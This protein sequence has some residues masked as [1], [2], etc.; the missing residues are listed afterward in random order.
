MFT[1]D[2]EVEESY[3]VGKKIGDKFIQ[4]SQNFKSIEFCGHTPENIQELPELAENQE[5]LKFGFLF[6]MID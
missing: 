6:A 5:L 2:E 4:S 3:H 1:I